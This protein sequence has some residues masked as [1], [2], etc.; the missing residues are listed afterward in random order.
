MP[1]LESCLDAVGEALYISVAD[2]LSAFWQL[3]VA[4][5][6][7][8]R[9]A[10]VTPR[11]KYCFKRMPF[12]VANAPWLFQHVTS[13]ALDHFGP[14]SGVLSYTDGLICINNTLESHLVSNEKMFAALQAAGC[15]L[16]PCL[17]SLSSML[18]SCFIIRRKNFASSSIA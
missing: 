9:T 17:S 4:E 3:P 2:I 18:Q 1:N 8:D 12:G 11:G 5:K 15:L 10:F 13:L 16:A 6:H 14:D 7:D